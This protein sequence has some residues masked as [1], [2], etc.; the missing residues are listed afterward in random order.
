MVGFINAEHRGIFDATRHIGGWQLPE[1]SAAL[2]ELGFKHGDVLLEVGTYAGRSAAC[3][4]AGALSAGRQPHYYGIDTSN[5]ALHMTAKT[6]KERGLR[7]FSALFF[8]SLDQFASRFSIRPTAAFIDGGHLYQDVTADI[9]VIR[10]I[11]APGTPLMF[12]DY[13][14]P[15]TP[16][17]KKAVDEAAGAGLLRISSIRGCCAVT[18]AMACEGSLAQPRAQAFTAHKVLARVHNA[19]RVL[20]GRAAAV[21]QR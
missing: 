11:V 12:H 16:G 3:M 13:A 20:I 17:V 1:D 4:L 5:V 10:R 19:V 8:G 6:L 21:V 9:A 2:F 15:E 18:V 14:N 7:P